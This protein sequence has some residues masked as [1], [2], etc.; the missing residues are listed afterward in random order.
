MK[1]EGQR[2]Q[3]QSIKNAHAKLTATIPRCF[4]WLLGCSLWLDARW[5]HIES[6]LKRPSLWY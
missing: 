5:F 3:N 6:S 4:V 1:F 2:R